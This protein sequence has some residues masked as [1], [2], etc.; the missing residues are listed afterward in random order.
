MYVFLS[1]FLCFVLCVDCAANVPKSWAHTR[2]RNP[3]SV[4]QNNNMIRNRLLVLRTTSCCGVVVAV[5]RA[6][7]I[8]HHA[9]QHTH[10][11]THTRV[12]AF[13]PTTS[14][15]PAIANIWQL[16]NSAHVR[17]DAAT[18][19]VGRYV[20]GYHFNTHFSNARILVLC[21][22]CVVTR[23][24]RRDRIRSKSCTVETHDSTRSVY[25]ILYV[26][27]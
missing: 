16:Q 23:V 25:T 18:V 12:F 6:K 26:C 21:V 13:C 19:V 27:F 14:N 9:I 24:W 11:N 22:C 15:P 3:F 4:I 17:Y 20:S 2:G 10:T 5:E 7:H 1:L 8:T